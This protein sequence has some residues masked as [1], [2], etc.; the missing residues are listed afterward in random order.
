MNKFRTG[1]ISTIVSSIFLIIVFWITITSLSYWGR[2]PN[3]TGMEVF[4][5][6]PKSAILD[7]DKD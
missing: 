4:L 6:I 7:F 2:Y 5:H 1:W 3:K